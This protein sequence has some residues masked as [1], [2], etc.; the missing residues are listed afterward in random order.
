MY[1]AC[2]TQVI[3][4]RLQNCSGVLQFFLFRPFLGIFYSEIGAGG[5]D[6]VKEFLQLLFTIKSSFGNDV[7]PLHGA[8]K[9]EMFS[10]INEA[11][12]GGPV[13]LLPCIR[14]LQLKTFPGND[15]NYFLTI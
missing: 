8:K 6:N 9:H 7:R 13:L 14:K 4:N 1:I 15:I 3:L 10:V 2:F 12:N 11:G 5:S